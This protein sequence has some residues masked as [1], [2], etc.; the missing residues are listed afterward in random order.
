MPPS[1]HS[2]FQT[3]KIGT[4]TIPTHQEK[5]YYTYKHKHHQDS[6]PGGEIF[7]GEFLIAKKYPYQQKETNPQDNK[8]HH[9]GIT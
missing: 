2:D 7:K 9:I 3:G 4:L 5:W 6:L 1:Q 8:Q